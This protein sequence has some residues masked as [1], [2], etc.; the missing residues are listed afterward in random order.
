M[1]KLKTR[2]RSLLLV[3]RHYSR[4]KHRFAPWVF[5]DLPGNESDIIPKGLE[6]SKFQA[7]KSLLFVFF[8][9]CGSSNGV[10][11]SLITSWWYSS[12]PHR[13]TLAHGHPPCLQV[14][15][16]H[17]T[18]MVCADFGWYSH[19]KDNSHVDNCRHIRHG[20]DTN[21]GMVFICFH[22]VKAT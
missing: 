20:L 13:S 10:G 3:Y 17:F 4:K 11:F 6:V 7:W 15:H 8:A 22:V 18:F 2:F 9:F 19:L 16:P 1:W 14:Y 21:V 12:R 5:E